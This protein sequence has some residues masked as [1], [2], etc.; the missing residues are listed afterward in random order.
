[1]LAV[2]SRSIGMM[3]RTVQQ[4]LSRDRQREQVSA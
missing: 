2:A 4:D 3:G 1:M